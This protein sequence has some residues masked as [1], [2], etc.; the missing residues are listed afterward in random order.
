MK[1]LKYLFILIIVLGILG[2]GIYYF[3]TNIA[4]EKVMSIVSTELED[5]GQKEE[6]KQTIEKDPELK[7]FIEDADNV[8]ESKL[9]FTT[10]EEATRV[11]VKKLGIS[12]IKDIQTKVQKGTISKKEVYQEIKGKLTD[13]EIQALKLIAY[14]ELYKK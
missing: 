4:S 11:L 6:L 7:A 14:K 3:G 8:D 9:P 1:F 5:S 13:D 12:E 10:K 2:Y